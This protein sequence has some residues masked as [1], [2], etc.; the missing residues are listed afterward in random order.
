MRIS[1]LGRLFSPLFAALLL[2]V[3]LLVFPAAAQDGTAASDSTL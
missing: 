3:G 1:K 2:A